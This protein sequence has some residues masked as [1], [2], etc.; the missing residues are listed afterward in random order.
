MAYRALSHTADTGL[1]ATAQTLEA[2]LTE[3]L[4]GMFALMARPE[5]SDAR[6][7][8]EV[9]IESFTMEDLVVDTLSELLLQSEMEDL[10]FCDFRVT[11]SGTTANVEAGGVPTRSVEAS[12]PPIKAV[13][14]HD[15]AVEDRGGEWY[16]RVYFDV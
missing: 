16:A 4:R 14:Y 3:L 5:P 10:L 15:L 2:L 7:W 12:G 6:S 8:V 9:D 1:E 11:V 13:T